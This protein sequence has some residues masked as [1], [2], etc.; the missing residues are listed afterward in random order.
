[1]ADLHPSHKLDKENRERQGKSDSHSS[2]FHREKGKPGKPLDYDHLI[3]TT[4]PQNINNEQP[5]TP[6]I[7]VS[8]W[9]R[10]SGTV[11][12]NYAGWI[13]I[14]LDNNANQSATISGNAAQCNLGIATFSNLLVQIPNPVLGEAY[15]LTLIAYSTNADTNRVY[16]DESLPFIVQC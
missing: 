9:G 15:Q 13:T 4:A 3:W 12:P 10:D 5:F 14:Q 11:N 16:S 8:C 7:Q 1:M 2:S 6:I